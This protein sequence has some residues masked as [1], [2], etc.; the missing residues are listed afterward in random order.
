[1]LIVYGLLI[2][3]LLEEKNKDIGKDFYIKNFEIERSKSQLDTPNI[4]PIKK[5][6]FKR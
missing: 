4:M 1:M 2:L 6:Q 3:L 5:M